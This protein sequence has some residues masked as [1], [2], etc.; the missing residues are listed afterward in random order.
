MPT[1]PLALV[2]LCALM[3]ACSGNNEPSAPSHGNTVAA[4]A[5][6]VDG[7]QSPDDLGFPIDRFQRNAA[8]AQVAMS[9][10]GCSG[11]VVGDRV[12]IS[13]A[14]CVVMNQSAWLSG[15]VPQ[16][17]S[18][19]D[20]TYVVGNDINNPLCVLQAESVQ[21]HPQA[22]TDP[23]TGA[24]RH[25]ISITILDSS[26]IDNCPAVVPVQ[27]NRDPITD[28]FTGDW[29]LQGGF[30]ALDYTYNF[31][32]V[33]YWSLQQLAAVAPDYVVF[34]SGQHGG[35]SFGDSGSGFLRRFPDGSL[36]TLGMDSLANGLLGSFV[37][38]D[39]QGSFIDQVVTPEL[40][41]GAV[42]PEGICRDHAVVA[43]DAHGFTSNDCLASGQ[44]C[45]ID[46]QGHA[47]C[48]C[49]CD[50]NAGCDASCAC[51]PSCADAGHEAGPDGD[52]DAAP[53]AAA[54]TC[55]TVTHL[56]NPASCGPGMA[57]DIVDFVASKTGC[58]PA[59][60]VGVY[61]EC[62]VS[63][64]PCIS[65]TTCLAL[66]PSSWK[67]DP[68]CNAN[69]ADP[70]CPGV[71]VCV[72]MYQ[73]GS[74]TAGVCMEPDNCDL[75][76]TSSCPSGYGCYLLEDGRFCFPAG[77]YNGGAS[78]T[79]LNDCRAGYDCLNGKCTRWCKDS[80]QCTGATVCDGFGNTP[81]QPDV[82]H[83]VIGAADGGVDAAA[84]GAVEDATADS[85]D[86]AP[87]AQDAP[88][89]AA[90]DAGQDPQPSP[91]PAADDSGC[92]CRTSG[93]RPTAPLAGL[94]LLLLVGLLRRKG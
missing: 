79:Y 47:A 73:V 37:R 15:A 87:A 41:C 26:V 13:A 34:R 48:V 56:L 45:A 57:C 81:A 44:D 16:V 8:V 94:G 67:C 77:S 86:D 27:I 85:S 17:A 82:G 38:T 22:A 91:E 3:C 24:I 76:S 69:I 6:V 90:A 83:C 25:D 23:S 30:G 80:S 35:P 42:G 59:G 89:E 28:S 49:A 92:G 12:V 93:T 18:P 19:Q 71:G 39:A 78:C 68:F 61:G 29:V 60:T 33:R 31:S 53:D 52:T 32:P 2:S 51:D 84:D 55:G 14:H 36:R 58:R 63:T 40:L 75:S 65:G 7:A 70:G 66:T 10:Q 20:L 1:R 21:V 46:G 11:T 43:C 88:V 62:S 64:P 4:Q 54:P 5:P 74:S 72:P 50:T 9:S